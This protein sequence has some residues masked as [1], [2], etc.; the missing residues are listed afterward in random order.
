[1]LPDQQEARPAVA[2]P[3]ERQLC[4]L[5]A[6][7]AGSNEYWMQ[8]RTPGLAPNCALWSHTRAVLLNVTHL[9]FAHFLYDVFNEP[10]STEN[11]NVQVYLTG[12]EE[13]LEFE[14]E[15][16][17]GAPFTEEDN[18]QFRGLPMMESFYVHANTRLSFLDDDGELA[19]IRAADQL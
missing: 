4:L 16:D 11:Q 2:D 19:Y 9:V 10:Q 14:V 12:L 7:N 13:K 1:V 6:K 17:F 18:G 5:R 15:A 3:H 8:T